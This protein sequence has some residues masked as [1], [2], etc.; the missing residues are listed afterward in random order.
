MRKILVLSIALFLV[1]LRVFSQSVISS[2]G[3]TATGSG[4]SLSWTIGEPVVST[5][6][7]PSNIL[8]Q[9][10]HQSK[11]TVTAVD[12]IK[13]PGLKLSVYP[14]P[15]TDKLN[16]HTEEI[17]DLS[18]I[19]MLFSND[20]KMLQNGILDNSIKELDMQKMPHGNYLL[21]IAQKRGTAIQI[22]KIVKN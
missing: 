6:T 3:T 14:N 13:I 22:F 21:K 4:Y 16:I 17:R 1:C 15:V 18:L 19:F 12:E 5:L 8:T 9:G 11:L 20:G 10:F 7:G 2:C